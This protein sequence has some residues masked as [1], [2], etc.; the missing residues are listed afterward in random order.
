MRNSPTKTHE[1]NTKK[2]SEVHRWMA[3]LF[4]MLVFSCNAISVMAQSSRK[5]S[6]ETKTPA[7]APA[8]TVLHNPSAEYLSGEV[9]VAVRANENPL[10]RLGL[11]QH[12]VT[13]VEFPANDRFFAIN[14]GN[15]DLVTIE[16]SPTKETDHFF[17]MRAGTSFLAAG[18]TGPPPTTS[19]IVQM[20]SGMV[21]TLLLTP[22]REI[23]RNAHRCVITYDRESVINSR[24]AAGLAVQLDRREEAKQ[25]KPT[26]SSVRFAPSN[27][28]SVQPAVAPVAPA[29]PSAATATASPANSTNSATAVSA[30]S[31]VA[32]TQFEPDYELDRGNWSRAHHGVALAAQTRIL[33]A[34]QRQV[35]VTVRNTTNKPIQLVPGHPELYVQTLDGK[36]R[37]LQAEQVLAVK[38][39]AEDATGLL[40]PRESLRYVITYA[41][42]IL[43]AKQRL[44]VIVAQTN[45]ADEPTVVELTAG[46]R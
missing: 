6:V 12:G 27:E 29:T 34:Q 16:D 9:S 30:L 40:A 3:L 21:V 18:N 35:A 22:V 39:E 42:P 1:E 23:E 25:S 32:E 43:G 28:A 7:N 31:V 5:G 2:G 13:L 20:T 10:I 4:C 44:S 8:V 24:R 38:F 36:Q 11:A 14:P 19:L 17:V 26:A 33:N 15:P 46:L 45:A 41:A 37:V